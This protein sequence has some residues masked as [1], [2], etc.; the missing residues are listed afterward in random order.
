MD[1]SKIIAAAPVVKKAWRWTPAPLRVPL[2]VAGA[3]VL[4]WKYFSGD[5]SAG[6]QGQA[7]AR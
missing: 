2:L 6:E 5:E 7:A 1:L 4:A 3:A